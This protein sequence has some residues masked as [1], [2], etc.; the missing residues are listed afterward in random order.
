MTQDVRVLG[1]H[2]SSV[3]FSLS[4]CPRNLTSDQVRHSIRECRPA[5]TCESPVLFAL[6]S[7]VSA[8]LVPAS[9]RWNST[10]SAVDDEL[11]G[12]GLGFL[13]TGLSRGSGFI[14]HF[15]RSTEQRVHALF[16]KRLRGSRSQQCPQ[17]TSLAHHGRSVL[18]NLTSV[19]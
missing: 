11:V 15:T 14:F 5:R 8:A 1:L 16:G 7:T 6:C 17:M 10:F 4:C 3:A 18:C 9:D 12:S 13:P 19:T 2:C